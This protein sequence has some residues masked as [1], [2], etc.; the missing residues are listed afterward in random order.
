MTN[1]K[2]KS[3]HIRWRDSYALKDGW[4]STKSYDLKV[5]PICETIGWLTYEDKHYWYVALNLSH[6]KDDHYDCSDTILIPKVCVVKK[7]FIKL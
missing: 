4:G 1:I 6:E 3:V 2:P 5:E 7:R